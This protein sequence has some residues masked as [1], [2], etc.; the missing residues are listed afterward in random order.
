VRVE[1]EYEKIFVGSQRSSISQNDLP[2]YLSRFSPYI[3][4]SM[5]LEGKA[6][7]VELSKSTPSEPIDMWC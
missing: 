7:I 5:R 6:E 3:P 1:E 4:I 2:Q